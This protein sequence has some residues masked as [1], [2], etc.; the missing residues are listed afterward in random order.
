MT[1]QYHIRLAADRDL[2]DQA[3]YLAQEA[4]LETALRFYDAS[5]VTFGRR[6][7]MPGLGERRETSDPSSGDRYSA[8]STGD[9]RRWK[10]RWRG[11]VRS[12]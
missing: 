1:A 6:A 8:P 5:G 9:L 12:G 11:L 2:D 3:A 7:A 4:S 10:P